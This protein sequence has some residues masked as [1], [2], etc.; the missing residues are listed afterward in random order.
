MPN[1]HYLRHYIFRAWKSSRFVQF[2]PSDWVDLVSRSLNDN[3]YYCC[4]LWMDIQAWVFIICRPFQPGLIFVGKPTWV[5][6]ISSAPPPFKVDSCVTFNHLT[7]LVRPPKDKHSSLLGQLANYGHIFVQ[8]WPYRRRS[9]AAGVI[10]F[11][12]T[13]RKCEKAS[14]SFVDSIR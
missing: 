4:N 9:A 2:R 5:E 10:P 14:A 6:H 8:H 7:K 3:A 13:R 1:F 12:W 11:T